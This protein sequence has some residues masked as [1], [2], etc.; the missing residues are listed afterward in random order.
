MKKAILVLLTLVISFTASGQEESSWWIFGDG[1]AVEFTPNPQNRSS[2]PFVVNSGFDQDEG[3]GAISDELG[4]LLF[5]TDGIR[6]YNRNGNIMPN[7]DGLLGNP[8]STQSAI[9]VKAPETPNV[10]F[11]VTVGTSGVLAYS[12]VEMD[13]NS[14]LGDVVP[15]IKNIILSRGCAEK[16]AATIQTGSNNAYV[17]SF[18]RSN[19]SSTVA[20]SGD[21]NALFAWEIRGIPGPNIS[22]VLP[23][24][25]PQANNLSYYPATAAT[26]GSDNGMLRVSP[27]GTKLAL[28]NH[29]FGLTAP[30]NGCFLYDFNPGN[31]QF[32]GAGLQLD[33]GFVY[34]IEF[35]ASSQYLYHDISP[36]YGPGGNKRLVQYDLCDPSNILATRNEFANVSEARGTLQLGRDGEI[37]VARFD[38]PWLG[39]IDGVETA[40]PSYIPQAVNIAPGLGKQGLPVFIQSSFASSFTVNDQCQGDTT[41]FILACLPQ[42]AASNWDFGDGNTLSV[43]G[44]GV[45]NHTYA[46]A[47][48]YTVQ[49]NVTNV[50]GDIRDFTQ[51]I[52]IFEN[53][54]VD[55][56]D[57]TLLDYCDDDGSGNEIVD[58]TQFTADV[59]GTQ[60][61]ATF[62][63]SYHANSTDADLDQNPLPDNFNAQLGTNE[64]WVRIA[65]NTSPIDD[66]CSAIGSFTLTVSSVPTVSNIPDFEFCDDASQDGFEDFD[67]ASF[68]TTIEAQAG[69]PVDVTYTIH[70][71]QLDA[72]MNMGAIDTSVLYTNTSSPQ[73]LYVRLQNVNDIDCFGTAPFNLVVL[74]FPTLGTVANIEVCDDAPLDGNSDFMLTDQD[75][76]VLNGGTGTVTYHSSQ[77]DADSGNAPL[78]SPYS[79]SGT[80]TIYAR[81]VNASG[82]S[83][84]TNFDITVQVAP[85]IG[86]APDLTNICDDTVDLNQNLFELSVQDDAVLNGLNPADYTITY[87]TT[88]ADAQNDTNA[89]PLSYTVP[90]QAGV[91]TDLLFARLENNTTGCFNTSQFTIIFDRCEI[92]FPEGF[93]PNGDGVNDTFSIP[94]LAEQY[95]NFT[96]QIFNRNGSVVFETS[97]NNYEEFAGIPNKGAL[98]GDGLLPV[99]TYFYLIKYNEADEEDT[100]SW[101][102][103]NY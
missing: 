41:E 75:N 88:D 82:C 93:S 27:D 65:N 74:P 99:G 48:T 66:G 17:M 51:D 32:G 87:Y 91:T 63:I 71:S 102:Y 92:I 61:A 3:V 15:G 52:T 18:A 83:G 73:T 64:I 49:V 101:L 68:L 81:L 84:T 14:G 47:G 29:N 42:V 5:F 77:A 44:P 26:S 72:D 38:E 36:N 13:L 45:V 23:A 53:G 20:G 50:S 90:F 89:L 78:T 70:E 57:V 56:V 35:S 33:T 94:G 58:L 96:L 98:A 34:G 103:I 43:S 7:G 85:A 24:P 86:N 11:I 79:V 19:S 55:P 28:G 4:N 76:A 54:I 25:V 6:V 39:R 10:Y 9:V 30:N 80:E 31:G 95:D 1:A 16:V 59:L 100:A 37:Y 62:D 2:E 8:S 21:F 46:A 60:D 22:F 40:T 97:A 12:R 69:N 67:L